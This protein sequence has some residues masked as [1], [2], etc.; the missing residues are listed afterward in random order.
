MRNGPKESRRGAKNFPTWESENTH[1]KTLEWENF[2]LLKLFSL[3]Q[4]LFVSDCD[5][6]LVGLGKGSKFS[7][8]LRM[9][10][11]KK[12]TNLTWFKYF[13]PLFGIS[14]KLSRTKGWYGP[15]LDQSQNCNLICLYKIEGQ[16]DGDRAQFSLDITFNVFLIFKCVSYSILEVWE[17]QA[18][19]LKNFY[20]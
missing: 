15:K 7:N 11:G 8:K 13:L 19:P 2:C 14:W 5:S 4:N 1:Q 18:A 17:R 9:R 20:P 3:S 10:W 6:C 16:T 12:K